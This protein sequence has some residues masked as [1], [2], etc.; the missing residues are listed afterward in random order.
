MITFK[1]ILQEYTDKVINQMVALYQPQTEDPEEQIK[2]N[3][4]RFE[5]LTGAIAKKLADQNPLIVA[6]IPD[7]L[8][9][10][11]KFR[12]ITQYKDYATL[13]KVLK[14]ADTK[15]VDVYKQAIE[16]YKKQDQYANPQVIGNYVARFKQNLAALQQAVEAKN[17]NALAVVPKELLHKDAYKNILNWRNFHTLENMLDTLFPLEGE[18]GESND[19]HAQGDLVYD[20][21]DIEIFKG[22]EEHKCVYYG[23]KY[24]GSYGW[25][26]GNTMYPSYRYMQSNAKLNRMFYFIFDRSLPRD[27]KYHAVV[28]HAFA[29]GGYTRTTAVNGDETQP[30]DWDE[31]GK[32]LFSN[33]PSG[34]RLWNKIKNL[35]SLFKFIPPNKDEQRRLG[36]RGA[37]KTLEEFI[38]MDNED[39]RDWLRANATDRNIVTSEIVKSIPPD[40]EVSRN[41]LINYDRKFNFDELKDSKQLLRRYAEYRSSR[42]PNEDLPIIFV[43]YLKEESKKR[44]YDKYKDIPSSLTVEFI[45]MFLNK[46]LLQDYVDNDAKRLWYIPE[47]Y[48]QYISNDKLKKLYTIYFKLLENWEYDSGTNNLK[49]LNERTEMPKQNVTPVPIFYKQ[50]ISL[51]REE[52]EAIL[53]LTKRA[54]AP[55]SNDP[56]DPNIVHFYAVPF[57]VDKYL[58]LP[59]EKSDNFYYKW[60]LLDPN[61][62]KI[63]KR[64]NSENITLGDD[65]ILNGY[66]NQEQ[67]RI[68]SLKDLKVDDK[69]FIL[70][71]SIYDDWDKYKFMLRAGIIK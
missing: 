52:Q 6:S 30:M 53:E 25:C 22:D 17:E 29:G 37:R 27:D 55:K 66:P 12:D 40:G 38:D 70:K 31:M 51:S 42:Y 11:N 56:N 59:E 15:S 5:Q 7:D 28:L 58:L 18:G 41:E 16:M 62:D 14:A 33:S 45:D 9:A 13:V 1:K 57:M 20:K 36:F 69:P 4:K 19:A 49:V 23:K 67:R 8:K 63:I 39:K 71:E 32:K 64:I 10:N 24:K 35:E 2:A 3:I 65:Q 26:I 50:W 21:D 44:Y 43:P 54:K 60:V 34:I 48:I 61:T 68:F 46:E 47:K